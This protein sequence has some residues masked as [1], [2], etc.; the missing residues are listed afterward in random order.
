[1]NYTK[2]YTV[3]LQKGR[4]VYTRHG[5]KAKDKNEAAYMTAE[6][7]FNRGHTYTILSIEQEFEKR[8]EEQLD[9]FEDYKTDN[10]TV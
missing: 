5:V 7:V 10:L 8:E 1:M 9:L 4:K 2:S 6:A 3:V